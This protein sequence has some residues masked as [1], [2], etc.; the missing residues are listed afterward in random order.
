MSNE[1]THTMQNTTPPN[2]GTVV[3]K[4]QN[5]VSDASAWVTQQTGWP[6]KSVEF[7]LLN[8]GMF[9]YKP[10]GEVLLRAEMF[11]VSVHGIQVWF[12]TEFFNLKKE[13]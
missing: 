11:D 13:D 5:P 6:Q 7:Y 4:G 8:Y 1:Q 12:N 10:D 3:F 2:H 9:T